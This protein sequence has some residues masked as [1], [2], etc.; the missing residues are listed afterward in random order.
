MSSVRKLCERFSIILD[1]SNV[2]EIFY[3][4]ELTNSGGNH[5]V[6]VHL[7]CVVSGRLGQRQEI[8]GENE[9]TNTGSHP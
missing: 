3:I 5:L 8:R 9:T 7:Y 1:D 6:P 2:N 4:D